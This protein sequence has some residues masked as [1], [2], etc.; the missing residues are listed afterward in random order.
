MSKEILFQK[1]ARL[2]L[3]QGIDALANAVKSTLGPMGRNVIIEKPFDPPHV[4]KDGVTVAKEISLKDPV[5]NMGADMIRQAASTTADLA[6]DGTTTSTILA[7]SMINKGLNAVDKGANPIG[8]KR[9]MIKALNLATESIKDMSEKINIKSKR[10][11]QVATISA[12]NDEEL[13]KLISKAIKSVGKEGIVTVE[14]SKTAQTYIE[15]LSGSQFDK[16]YMSPYFTTDTEKMLCEYDE[17]L[18]LFHDGGIRD[19]QSLVPIIEASMHPSVDRPIVIIADDVMDQ[20]L[21]MLVANKMKSGARIVAIKAPSFGDNRKDIMSDLAVATGGVYVSPTQG[22][23]MSQVTINHLGQ[24]EKIIVTKDRTIIISGRG[25]KDQIQKRINSIKADLENAS[26]PQYKHQIRER[27]GKL[28][29]SISVIH[30]GAATELE[31]REKK[32][33][34]EDAVYATQAALVEGIVPGSGY[35]LGYIGANFKTNQEFES[36]DEFIGFNIVKESLTEPMTCIQVNAGMIPSE[37]FEENLGFDA[38]ANEW[39]DLKLSGIVDPAKVTRVALENAVSVASTVLT[40]NVT[41]NIIPENKP[42]DLGQFGP[43]A[44]Y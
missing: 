1:D 18:I 34:V 17:P 6:G 10:L 3:R 41:I 13:G 12:N 29:N 31:M 36:K 35:A 27:L 44:G 37:R 25:D 43:M 5:Q 14:A 23:E 11:A 39:V 38:L 42:K 21:N 28:S 22:V 4:T 8:V 19:I 20:A 24:A 2:K 26:V 40:T 32:D 16:G 9:G 7:Q 15:D 33:R 30:V